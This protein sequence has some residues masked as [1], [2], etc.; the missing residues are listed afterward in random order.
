MEQGFKPITQ[1]K[2][3]RER[4]AQKKFGKDFCRMLAEIITNSDDS[5]RNLEEHTTD[6]EYKGS[7]KPIYIS[8]DYPKH[9]DYPVF[10]IVDNAEG[11]NKAELDYVFEKYGADTAHGLAGGSRGLYGQGATDVVD[12]ARLNNRIASVKSIKD[13]KLYEAEFGLDENLNLHFRTEENHISSKNLENFR[14]KHRIPNN[15]TIVKFGLPSYIKLPSKPEELIERIQ[16]FYQ[17]RYLLKSTNNRNVLLKSKRYG[18]DDYRLVSDQYCFD[19]SNFLL[20][21]DFEFQDEDDVVKCNIRFYKNTEKDINET[22][23]LVIDDKNNVYDNTMFNFKNDQQSANIS[24]VLHIYKFYN[25]CKERLNRTDKKKQAIVLDNRTGFDTK[26]SFYNSLEDALYPIIKRVLAEHGE[27]KKDISLSKN[28]QISSALQSINKYLNTILEEDNGFGTL[29]GLKA[30]AEGIKFQRGTIT[31]TAGKGYG[32]KLLINTDLVDINSQIRI[33]CETLNHIEFSPDS[34][35]LSQDDIVENNL[36]VKNIHVDA[37]SESVDPLIMTAKVNDLETS[38]IINVIAEE[39]YYPNEGMEFY[40]N[41]I[42]AVPGVKHYATLYVDTGV[43]PF[44]SKIEISSPTLELKTNEIDVKEDDVVGT[45]N[46]VRV[47][48]EFGDGV[49]GN[50]YEITASFEERKAT[51]DVEFVDGRQQSSGKKG[52]I[53]DI[54]MRFTPKEAM[55]QAFMDDHSGILYITSNNRIN[56]VLFNNIEEIDTS[57]PSFTDHQKRIV[58]D[59]VA[60][61]IARYS[62][63]KLI[64]K[65][66]ISIENGRTSTYLSILQKNKVEIFD[67][68]YKALVGT[69]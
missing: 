55:Y 20:E 22:Y 41:P 31:T 28:K 54:Q 56:K 50:K 13:G 35:V 17:F 47:K 59:I 69:K 19:E 16:K 38:V 8:L 53:S 15:G 65:G 21:K 6:E 57:K 58:S 14:I 34:F 64:K 4:D 2:R 36:A 12:A 62:V 30:P 9:K 3:K 10:T 48:I 43:I 33:D 45:S 18:F 63:D 27:A 49:I 40:K 23:F 7:I 1:D 51:L 37:I 52:L 46:I 42:T 61:E 60:F 39:I 26:E 24:G 44:G 67:V 29:K 32:L 5:Y 68:F 66:K 11:M 25:I